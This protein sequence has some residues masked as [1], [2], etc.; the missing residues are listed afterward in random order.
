MNHAIDWHAR[1][2]APPHSVPQ[3]HTAIVNGRPYKVLPVERAAFKRWL[4]SLGAPVRGAWPFYY[5]RNVEKGERHGT[6]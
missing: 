5:A 2:L 6:L 3:A 4:A 1:A